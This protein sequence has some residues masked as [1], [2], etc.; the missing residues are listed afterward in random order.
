MKILQNTSVSKRSIMPRQSF[1]LTVA[2]TLFACIGWNYRSSSGNVPALNL[3]KSDNA[4]VDKPIPAHE[5]APNFR[6]QLND[7][8]PGVNKTV[9]LDY[10]YN[11]EWK[12]AGEKKVQYHYVWE[13]TANSGFSD[14]G[15]VI[16]GLGARIVRSPEAPTAQFLK[17]CSVYIIVDPDTPDETEHPHYIEDSD[18]EVIAGWVKDGGTLV[19]MGNDKGNAEFDHLNRL[20][21]YFGIHFNEDSYHRVVGNQ[22]DEGKFS[23][24]PDHPMF[25]GVQQIYLKEICS[26]GLQMPAEPILSEGGHVFMACSHYGKGLVF[27]VGD[28][29][30]YNEYV[31]GRKLPPSYKNLKAGEN[32]F[33]WLL[34][35]SAPIV[36]SR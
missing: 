31:N 30:L 25:A 19:L 15:K 13:D 28:P 2:F 12:Q 34:E 20:S 3:W 14:L 7:S 32:L 5:P 29:W 10:Y 27:A 9:A 35:Q 26:L 11:C 33:R 36:N 8:L 21:G 18:A 17:R 4:I 6:T 23:S 24:L 16:V 22:F 1:V